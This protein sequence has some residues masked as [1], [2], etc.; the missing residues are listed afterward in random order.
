MS[1]LQ[2]ARVVLRCYR[3]FTPRASHLGIERHTQVELEETHIRASLETLGIREHLDCFAGGTGSAE[4][5]SENF[6]R[7]PQ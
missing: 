4:L 5:L 1:D 6:A 3:E 7:K 2:D